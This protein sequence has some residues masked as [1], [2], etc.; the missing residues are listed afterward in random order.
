LHRITFIRRRWLEAA[1]HHADQAITIA[2]RFGAGA[3]AV[4][5]GEA[6]LPPKRVAWAPDEALTA[7]DNGGVLETTIGQLAV[8]GAVVEGARRYFPTIA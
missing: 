8:H 6:K 5:I 2:R 7:E 3:V 4:V 1:L